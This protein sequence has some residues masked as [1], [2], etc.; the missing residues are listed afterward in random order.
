MTRRLLMASLSA[1]SATI[2]RTVAETLARRAP[3]RPRSG[4]PIDPKLRL[5]PLPLV[6]LPKLN[7]PPPAPRIYEYGA[8][9]YRPAP[10]FR[11]PPRYVPRVRPPVRPPVRII[12]FF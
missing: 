9:G 4:E 8:P 7:L 10:G 3:P 6:E 1:G 12:P 5:K 11:P 2:D